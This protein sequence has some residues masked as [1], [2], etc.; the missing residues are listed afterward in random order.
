MPLPRLEP[1][2]PVSSRLLF[3]DPGW[4][5]EFKYDGYRGLCCI[6]AGRGRF[7][8][9]NGNTLSRFSGLAAQVAAELTW[10]MRSSMAR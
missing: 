1:I 6:E 7:I 3:N 8:S 9:R 4:L 5:F 2:I 10:M